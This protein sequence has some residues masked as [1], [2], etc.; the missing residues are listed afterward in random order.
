MVIT[1]R[2]AIRCMFCAVIALVVMTLTSLVFMVALHSSDLA[3]ACGVRN[4]ECVK[5]CPHCGKSIDEARR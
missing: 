3:E 1:T 5:L 2:T 4:S